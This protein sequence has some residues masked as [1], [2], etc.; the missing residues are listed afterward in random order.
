V[1]L[2][3]IP[4]E[5]RRDGK[6]NIRIERI[7]E[8]SGPMYEPELVLDQQIAVSG[9]TLSLPFL[10]NGLSDAYVILISS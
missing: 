9:N 10:W 5:I 2:Q 1:N 3:N 6:I 8:G 7:P 4:P